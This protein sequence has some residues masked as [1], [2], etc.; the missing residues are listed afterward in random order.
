VTAMLGW[1][2]ERVVVAEGNHALVGQAHRVHGLAGL[3]A[4][5]DSLPLRDGTAEVVC[6][7]DVIEH[8][9]EPVSALVEARR[10][11]SPG[12]NL[13]VNVPAHRWLWS[14]AD[15]ALGHVRR[16]TRASLRAELD[17]AGFEPVMITHVFSWLVLPVWLKR[18]VAGGADAELGLDQTG[19]VVD[20]A[21][22]V[23][24]ALERLLVSRVS[25][26]LGTSILCVARPRR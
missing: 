18:R 16:Y 8:L 7:L 6:L 15:E 11:L 1:P 20:R 25:S 3:Q 23:L 12:G 13:V 24:T 21:A 4:N 9:T 5:V 17:A 19:V 22:M 26:P 14:S 10:L 2:P